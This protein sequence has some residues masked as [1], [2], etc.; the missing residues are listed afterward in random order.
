MKTC[1]LFDFMEEIKP[2]LDSDHIKEAFIDNKGHFVLKFR[3]G[4]QNVY[5]IDDCNESQIKGVLTDLKS[6]GIKVLE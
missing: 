6:K 4:M 5:L 2:W 1:N 3:D